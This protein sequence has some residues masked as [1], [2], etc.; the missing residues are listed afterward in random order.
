MKPQKKI[1]YSGPHLY[2]HIFYIHTGILFHIVKHYMNKGKTIHPN[3]A[4]RVDDYSLHPS[5]NWLKQCPIKSREMYKFPHNSKLHLFKEFYMKN[6]VMTPI[7][8]GLKSISR[9]SRGLHNIKPYC[10]K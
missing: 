6:L 3:L 10:A 1:L 7:L 5:S 4:I 2:D 8:P 9:N